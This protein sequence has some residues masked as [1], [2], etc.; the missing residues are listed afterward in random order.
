MS[1]TKNLP[2][3]TAE[4]PV[5]ENE[6]LTALY[7]LNILDTAPE[8]RFDR[9]TELAADV[10]NVPIVLISLVDENRQWFKSSCGFAATQTPRKRAFCSYAIH[11]DDIMLVDDTL[12]DERFRHNPLVTGE[13]FVRSYAGA[14]LH[15]PEGLPLGTLCLIDTQPRTFSKKEQRQLIAFGRLV[16]AEMNQDI[17]D[18]QSRMRSQLSAH[19]D[20]MTGFFNYAEFCNRCEAI[21]SPQDEKGQDALLFISLPQL[22]FI[23]RVHGLE[24]Y[25]SVIGPVAQIL[26]RAFANEETLFGRQLR[27]GLLVFINGNQQS[28]EKLAK[29]AQQALRDEIQLPSS[30]PDLAIRIGV[31]KVINNIDQTTYHCKAAARSMPQEKGIRYN[32]FSDE[33]YFAESR[34]SDIALRLLHA[35]EEDELNLHFQPKVS[36]STGHILG[37]EALLRWSDDKLGEVPPEEVVNAAVSADLVTVLDNWV[38]AAAIKQ[39]AYW[40]TAGLEPVPISI[41]LGAESFAEPALPSRIQTLLTTYNV[42]AELLQIEVLETAIL[43]DFDSILPIMQAITQIG[44]QFALDDF[45]TEYSSLRYLQKL[46]ISVVKIDRSFVQGL[47][48]NQEDAAL[49]MGIISIAHDLGMEVIAEGVENRE[50]YV[51]L[52]SFQ[53]DGIQGNLFRA[54]CPGD[55]IA[56]YLLPDFCF[57]LPAFHQ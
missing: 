51:V 55:E 16:Q 57:P 25:Q 12:T 48:A 40:Q 54:A 43:Q 34:A 29:K 47:V 45:G 1:N 4:I 15:S 26:V 14:V 56:D 2:Y 42:P 30:V 28:L 7:K 6:R 13:P 39:I 32:I 19:L 37:A 33:D 35:I 52:R 49:A 5:N 36:V 44:V 24:I 31:A 38:L 46:P 8:P 53:C 23:Y 27:E 41:N 10:L 11:Y 9:L 21:L 17:T 18:A 50:Q 3:H 20:P 22:D